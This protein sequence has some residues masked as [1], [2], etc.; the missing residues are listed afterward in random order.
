MTET[1]MRICTGHDTCISVELFQVFGLLGKSSQIAFDSQ[2]RN[3]FFLPAFTRRLPLKGI[4]ENPPHLTSGKD[5][6]I[7]QDMFV[8]PKTP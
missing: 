7:P 3:S 5:Y 6:L 2:L 4:F 8:F 1:A